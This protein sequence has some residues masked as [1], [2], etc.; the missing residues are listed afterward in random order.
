MQLVAGLIIIN[1]I[2]LVALWLDRRKYKLFYDSFE[3]RN[4]DHVKFFIT[5]GK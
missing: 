1:I 2:V 4:P 5:G 3:G